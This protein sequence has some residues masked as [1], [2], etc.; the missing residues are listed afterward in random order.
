MLIILLVIICVFMP[1]DA[2]TL[3]LILMSSDYAE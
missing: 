2:V 3:I 1:L